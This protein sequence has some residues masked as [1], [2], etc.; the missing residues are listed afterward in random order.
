MASLDTS[1]TTDK[2]H[3]P[4]PNSLLTHPK[5][6]PLKMAPNKRTTTQTVSSTSTTTTSSTIQSSS[7]SSSSSTSTPPIVSKAKRQGQSAQDIALGI[8]ENYVDNTPQRTKLIDVFM[9]F[10]VVVG[11]LQFVYCVLVGNFVCVS[12][13]FSFFLGGLC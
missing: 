10:L 4:T 6:K 7:T 11:A 3:H 1:T 2:I 9:A 12:F 8:W 5:T 13:S